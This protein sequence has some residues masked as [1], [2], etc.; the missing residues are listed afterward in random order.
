MDGLGARAI[1]AVTAFVQMFKRWRSTLESGH[2]AQLPGF[3]AQVITESGLEGMHLGSGDEEGLE[4]VANLNELVS[5]AAEFE[6]CS[7]SACPVTSDSAVATRLFMGCCC[8]AS[9]VRKLAGSK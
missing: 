8:S 3:V 5:A 4:R 9:R 1:R 6:R 2:L 7:A